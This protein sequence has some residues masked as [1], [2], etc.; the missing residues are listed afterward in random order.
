M[1]SCKH[2]GSKKIIKSGFAS[3]KQRYLCKEC[4]KLFAIGN[5]RSKSSPNKKIKA[6]KL[7]SVKIA[8]KVTEKANNS[9]SSV[10]TPF[11]NFIRTIKNWLKKA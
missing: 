5:A 2:C 11:T 1:T 8:P 4:N 7:H 9:S 3:G 10:F 6:E